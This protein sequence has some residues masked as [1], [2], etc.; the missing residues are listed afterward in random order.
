MHKAPIMPRFVLSRQRELDKSG[1]LGTISM[2][3]SK[4][5]DSMSHELLIN[6]LEANGLRKYYLGRRKQRSKIGSVFS[7]M[8]KIINGIPQGLI[9]G[10]LLFNISIN[11]LFSLS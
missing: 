9:L 5:Y 4:L 7:E 10:P 2:D 6:K 1:L 3:L 8:C 11:N